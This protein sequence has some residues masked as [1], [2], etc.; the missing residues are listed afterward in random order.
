MT[1]GAKTWAIVK[2]ISKNT[3][4]GW[5]ALEKQSRKSLDR[6]GMARF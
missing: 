6:A 5:K 4:R 1:V 3:G 2:Q